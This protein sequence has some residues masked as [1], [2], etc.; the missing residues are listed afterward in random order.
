M[1]RRIEDNDRNNIKQVNIPVYYHPDVAF[2]LA[3]LLEEKQLKLARFVELHSATQYQ[4]YAI[5]FSPNFAFLA[6]VNDTIQA[7]RLGTPRLKIPA[8]SIG[9]AN[10]Q[11]AV[12]P[13]CSSGGWNII[14]RT[15][16]D[17]SLT[18]ANQYRQFS[19][20]DQVKFQP[21]SRDE[22]LRQGG[23]F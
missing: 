18:Q 14:G 13:S 22:Y 12:Y 1:H 6:K 10:A 4:V 20:G 2:D 9:I 17:L 15:P 3:R 21:I 23:K 19:V 5:G 8:G 16:L 7:P 11:T